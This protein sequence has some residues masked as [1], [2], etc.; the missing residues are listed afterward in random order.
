MIG[1]AEIAEKVNR[2]KLKR[3]YSNTKQ[4]LTRYKPKFQIVF[5]YIEQNALYL[6]RKQCTRCNRITVKCCTSV[7][8][9]VCQCA[10]CHVPSMWESCP[11]SSRPNK[12]K[13]KNKQILICNF[14]DSFRCNIRCKIIISYTVQRT[15]TEYYSCKHIEG[16]YSVHQSPS[17]RLLKIFEHAKRLESW[18]GAFV[19]DFSLYYHVHRGSWF[20]SSICI[21]PNRKQFV[22]YFSSVSQF[23]SVH[24]WA[25]RTIDHTRFLPYGS[26][27][28]THTHTHCALH[29]RIVH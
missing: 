14:P 2:L 3:R 12:N 24:F 7:C 23:D 18:L 19:E 8:V 28:M 13:K 4:N 1:G 9:P 29:C 22:S 25:G 21:F 26:H 6:L 15:A 10:M 11:A 5:D 27:T 20:Y 16:T 17:Y